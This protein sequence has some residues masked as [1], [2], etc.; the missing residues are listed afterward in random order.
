MGLGILAGELCRSVYGEQWIKFKKDGVDDAALT[1]LNTTGYIDHAAFVGT[2]NPDPNK[3][4]KH[5]IQG[6]L[7]I[8]NNYFKAPYTTERTEATPPA[9]NQDNARYGLR[10]CHL[11]NSRTA[12]RPPETDPSLHMTTSSTSTDII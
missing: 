4:P 9:L 12:R 2:I 8:Y 11:K 3:N 7:N 10:S 5:L 1:T 6:Y